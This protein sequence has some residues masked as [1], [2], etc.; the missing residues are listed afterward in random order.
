[1]SECT[2]A[3]I[4]CDLG[5]K[6]STLCILRAD[7]RVE[8]PKPIKTVRSVSDLLLCSPTG[9]CG[10][11]SGRA[12]AVGER[13]SGRARPSSDGGKCSTSEADFSERLEIR[14]GGRG[15]AGTSWQGRRGAARADSPSRHGSTGGF[16]G[17][18]S[19]RRIGGVPDETNQHLSGIGEELRRTTSPVQRR[20]F[21]PS[22]KGV[23]SCRAKAGAGASIS[24][25]RANRRGD[26]EGRQTG[27]K[28]GQK[29]SGRRGHR[30]TERSGNI[31]RAGFPPHAGR[32][33]SVQVESRG[34][35]ICRVAAEEE[36]VRRGRPA[37]AD[38]ES[39]RS[40]LEKAAG[41]VRQLH[42]RSLREGQRLEALGIGASETG[43]KERTQAS[44]CCRCSEDGSADASAMGDG[45][46]L[47]AFGIRH[48]AIG[49]LTRAREQ[50]KEKKRLEVQCQSSAPQT[51]NHEPPRPGDCE[52]SLEL[53]NSQQRLQRLAGSDPNVHRAARAAQPRVRMEA[54]RSG[55]SKGC[56]STAVPL[57]TPSGLLMEASTRDITS[58]ART[59]LGHLPVFAIG[60]WQRTAPVSRHYRI[61]PSNRRRDP[62]RG[63]CEFVR[64]R[65]RWRPKVA[66][67]DR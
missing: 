57:L 27:G 40:I 29:V 44:M 1:M 63:A 56:W 9:P 39:G 6:Q 20:E 17:A 32:Q 48:K 54:W 38:Y 47:R 16:G 10:D 35:R 52:Y 42:A 31:Q 49:G 41:S 12:F 14:P 18:Q 58:L 28:T 66:T 45:G 65:S 37:A 36:S 21:P 61:A 30:P 64:G 55:F 50:I 34:W 3:V 22:S 24:G 67:N 62:R 43:W 51:R 2:T 13:A 5:D 4:G 8:R 11:R 46:G 15:I 25:V 19:T 53:E 59:P 33:E 60:F 26:S 23:R 7:G